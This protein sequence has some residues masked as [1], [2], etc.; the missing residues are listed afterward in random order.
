MK[1]LHRRAMTWLTVLAMLA[2]FAAAGP[3]IRSAKA[4]QP[5]QIASD[6]FE[7]AAGNQSLEG[8]VFTPENGEGISGEVVADPLNSGNRVLRLYKDPASSTS[9]IMAKRD[10]GEPLKGQVTLEFKIMFDTADG[11]LHHIGDVAG[12][13]LSALH[14]TMVFNGAYWVKNGSMADS[15]QVSFPNTPVDLNVWNTMKIEVDTE[16][17]TYSQ[18]FNDTLVGED[19]GMPVDAYDGVR[20]IIFQNR[21]GN[22][23][24]DDLKVSLGDTELNYT[25]IS[26]EV[27]TVNNSEKQ[28]DDVV[29]ETPVEEFLANI[30]FVEGAV[31]QVCTPDGQPTPYQDVR[32]GDQLVVSSP[33]GQSTDTYD[34]H[35]EAWQTS[36]QLMRLVRE[37][38]ILLTG[39]NQALV[40]NER[41]PIDD[42]PAVTPVVEDGRT[43]VPVRFIAEGFGANVDYDGG[44]Q[45]VTVRYRGK[46][47]TLRIG[48][49]FLT[50]DGE[51]C[52]LDVP[53]QLRHD[54]TLVPMRALAEAMG[55]FVF[56]DDR[57]LIVI[58]DQENP[59]G[60]LTR[61]PWLTDLYERLGV[62]THTRFDFSVVPAA[63][64]NAARFLYVASDG[65]DTA[66]GDEAHP[67]ATLAG[68]RDRIRQIKEGS[69]LPQGGITVYVREGDYS[70][71]ETFQ[72]TKEDSGTYASPIVYAN[73]PGENPRINGGK[74]LDA[75]AFTPVT[76]AAIASRLPAEVRDQVM[77]LDLKT[78]GITQ[79]DPIEWTGMSRPY[80]AGPVSLYFNGTSATLARW[81]N[82]GYV[83]TGEVID[84]GSKPRENE[85]PDRGFIFT[86]DD[87]RPERWAEP[88][89]AWMYGIW[90]YGYADSVT[91][92]ESIDKEAN[93]IKTV[94][95]HQYS[96]LP[97]KD[98]YY[99]NVLEELDMPGEYYI[100]RENCI[101]YLYPPEDLESAYITY[102][103]L[104]ADLV[105]IN[106][107]SYVTLYG[108]TIESGR[109]N[110]VS[111]NGGDNI[112]IDQCVVR[113]MGD[114]GVVIDGA[115]NSGIQNS[116]VYDLGARGVA[117][118]GGDRATLTPYGNFVSNNHIFL[119]S[120]VLHTYKAGVEIGGVGT[121]ISHNIIHSGPQQA[122]N[123][124][125]GGTNY[126]PQGANDVILEYNDVY[127]VLEPQFS[128]SGAYY[129][130]LDGAQRGMVIRYNFFH[131]FAK[132]SLA[133][134]SSPPGAIYLD[135]WTSGYEVYGNVF[136]S[137]PVGCHFNGGGYNKIYNNVFVDV[138][139][140]AW[141]HTY[142][143]YAPTEFWDRLTEFDIQSG[144]WAQK[145][146]YLVNIDMT[147][148]GNNVFTNNE[149]TGNLFCRT[150][151]DP[152]GS[153]KL[154]VENNYS[155]KV[156][157]GF[158]DEDGMDFKLRDN[159]PVLGKIEGF[160]N[161]PT[162]NMGLE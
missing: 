72:L 100:D 159:S 48:E 117:V 145:Y 34:I 115:K 131:H 119:F 19:Y 93:T 38:V 26:S 13:D 58:S 10:L 30:T 63:G 107:A 20:G 138:V 74:V 8:W 25:R 24:I 87:E 129:T 96:V 60:S 106:N 11:V 97:G 59:F 21:K 22:M 33:D 49:A 71:P 3:G 83:K 95:P 142:R 146:P 139:N 122:F 47:L 7:D 149:I 70:L 37:S 116:V 134:L 124:I 6:N 14:Q 160:E 46:K 18:Y 29:F 105:S 153:D 94:Y 57:G 135:N 90:Y 65:D 143:T 66:E 67:L 161:I 99:Y 54:R 75:S 101:L 78:Q 91:Q 103:E 112:L 42:D 77:Q 132:Q 31:P 82:E 98:Y 9:E 45:T 111:V 80:P 120:Q 16:A 156:N 86:Y 35:V 23:Y 15:A 44:T 85:T 28:I 41:M 50:V 136:Y 152:E 64:A 123:V 147:P 68:A 108:L 150:L 155:T 154:K 89:K 114:T 162:E 144:T 118:K 92:I 79:V 121:K 32:N 148:D 53:A 81:P 69:G 84:P 158:V 1:V 76:D 17:S 2:G 127:G 102:P 104:K 73:Y 137:L 88:E 43:L 109:C 140:P 39:G 128:D 126:D 56:W 51:Q 125:G 27:Y 110:G 130:Y 157:E 12:A 61:Q 151:K 36:L 40:R 4:A 55:K 113:E 141:L 5:R 52:T 62:T 133:D